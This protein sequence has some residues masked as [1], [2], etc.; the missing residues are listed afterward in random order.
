MNSICPWLELTLLGAFTPCVQDGFS[1]TRRV[2]YLVS[3]DPRR[4][5]DH[6]DLTRLIS[7]TLCGIADHTVQMAS[8][9]PFAGLN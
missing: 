5:A 6:S 4:I 3:L 8:I 2:A 9:E 1:E 7:K